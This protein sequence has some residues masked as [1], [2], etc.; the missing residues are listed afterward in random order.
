MHKRKY[1]PTRIYT[2]DKIDFDSVDFAEV[3]TID[4]IGDRIDRVADTVDYVA[5]VRNTDTET[6]ATSRIL[7][8][9]RVD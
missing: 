6:V 9:H 7:I 2:G 4:R 1:R 3:D 5:S 8:K